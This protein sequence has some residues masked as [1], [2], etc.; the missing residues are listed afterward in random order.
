MENLS[1]GDAEPQRVQILFLSASAS[2]REILS[3]FPLF[4]RFTKWPTLPQTGQLLPARAPHQTGQR[5]HSKAIPLPSANGVVP[6]SPGLR[7]QRRYPG[8]GDDDPTNHKVVVPRDR[9][10]GIPLPY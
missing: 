2:L 6:Y 4:A 8:Y 3:P 7:R 9:T 1:R 10:G 5:P